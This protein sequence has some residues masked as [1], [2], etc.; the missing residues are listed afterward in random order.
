MGKQIPPKRRLI[1]TRLQDI[2][3]QETKFLLLY[4]KYSAISSHD[5][6]FFIPELHFPSNSSL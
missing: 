2:T 4:G 6:P 5:G 1:H 3:S